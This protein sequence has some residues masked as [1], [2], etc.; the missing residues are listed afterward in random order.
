M[1]V[2]GQLTSHEAAVVTTTMRVM[3]WLRTTRD[4]MSELGPDGPTLG[5][6][7]MAHL[8]SA[9]TAAQDAARSLSRVAEVPTPPST[10]DS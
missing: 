4:T 9:R 8:E 6:V 2:L 3:E 5:K 1:A 7:A 10:S